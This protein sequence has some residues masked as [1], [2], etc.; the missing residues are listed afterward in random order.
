MQVLFCWLQFNEFFFLYISEM[1][2]FIFIFHFSL[3]LTLSLNYK[4]LLL[5]CRSSGLIFFHVAEFNDFFCLILLSFPDFIEYSG[6]KSF[7]ISVFKDFFYSSGLISFFVSE[8]NDFSCLISLSI[9]DFNESSGLIS[10]A[11]SEF[12]RFSCLISFSFTD[13]DESSGRIN[14]LLFRNFVTDFTNIF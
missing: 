14:I 11:V 6:F 5:N 1:N 2:F 3:L 4:E 8:F 9:Y 13:L 10:S 12:N 7:S